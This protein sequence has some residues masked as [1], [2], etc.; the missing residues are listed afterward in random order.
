M[1]K[2]LGILG[3]MG[4]DATALFYKKIIQNTSATCDQEHIPTI[5]YSN[6]K[7][8]DRTQNI[9]NNTKGIVKNEL[10]KTL[11]VLINANVACIAM[12]CN[13]AH[14]WI[15][16]LQKETQI[17]ILN[18][19]QE[20]RLY[21]ES[22]KINRVGIIGTLGTMKT[23][24]YQKE[25]QKSS[26]TLITPSEK[27]QSDIMEVITQIKTGSSIPELQQKVSPIL[28]QLQ[29]SSSS[30]VILGCTELPLLFEN[31]STDFIIDPMDILA[32]KAINT[33]LKH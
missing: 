7:I 26:T 23:Q 13:T 5:I 6:S 1:T 19:I 25:F 17:P 24:I 30:K 16:E 15:E 2:T 20:T 33:I 14:Y 22:K 28:A 8:P 29:E 12:P 3:G 31:L 32:Q 27:E 9:F 4:P 10:I 21:I 11:H 18:M